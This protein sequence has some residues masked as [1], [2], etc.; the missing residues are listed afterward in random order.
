MSLATA[1][2]ASALIS[3]GVYLILNRSFAR[4][5]FGF[6]TLS[7]GVNVFLLGM[8]GSP[9]G[10]SAP[11]LNAGLQASV[12]P[13]PQALILTAIVIGFGVTTYLVF[14][15]YRIFVDHGTADAG[16][17]FAPRDVTEREP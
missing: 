17:L 8:S 9:E 15:L 14:L 13:L 12:D 4:I 2:L 10:K 3:G 5:L 1:V 7:N 11:I 16:R 6:I